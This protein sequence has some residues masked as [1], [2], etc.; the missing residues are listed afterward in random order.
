MKFNL[1]IFLALTSLQQSAL[2]R[3]TPTA[4]VTITTASKRAFVANNQKS[5][6]STDD[7]AATACVTAVAPGGGAAAAAESKVLS[8]AA[9]IDT[10]AD[11][12]LIRDIEMLSNMLAEV[13]KKENPVVY[14][15][16]TR[17]RKHGMDR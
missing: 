11:A 17:F 3:P 9:D 10:V 12:P 4:P 13:V 15:L 8:E 1:Y 16:Y 6:P 2:A 7:V 5:A 14:D